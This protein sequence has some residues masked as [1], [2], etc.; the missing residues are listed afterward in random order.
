MHPDDIQKPA[1]MCHQGR[2][3]FLRI[4]FGVNNTPAVFQELMQ[5]LFRNC[6]SFCCPYMDDLVIFSS[7]WEDHI[8]HVRQVLDKL[9]T[10][11][12]IANPAKCHWGGTRMEFLG[13]LVG[14]GTMSVPQHQVEAF[15]KYSKPST[16]KAFLGA[17]AFYRRYIE[18]LAKQ[19]A[20]LTPLTSK[21]A[22]SKIF[23]TEERELAFFIHMYIYFRLLFP[24]YSS[25][26]RRLFCCYR[27]LW[28][29]HRRSPI[30]A[31]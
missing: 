18:L 23:W 21:L 16:K 26:G 7:N 22:P 31:T 13:H 5:G 30:G 4:L 17:I 6:S 28:V 11:G 8:E 3:E 19:T 14:E 10:A 2:F 29:G 20:V 9:R 24:V 1:F 15:A 27:C 12:L 25:P